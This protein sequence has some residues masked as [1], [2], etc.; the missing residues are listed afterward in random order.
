[1]AE[2]DVLWLALLSEAIVMI[3]VVAWVVR[4]FPGSWKDDE[5]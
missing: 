3:V 5:R 2:T 1:M 4:N